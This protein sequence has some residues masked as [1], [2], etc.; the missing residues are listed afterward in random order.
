MQFV[1]DKLTVQDE[2]YN[3]ASKSQI[4]LKSSS[5]KGLHSASTKKGFRRSMQVDILSY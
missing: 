1:C 3:W 5:N 2:C 4:F